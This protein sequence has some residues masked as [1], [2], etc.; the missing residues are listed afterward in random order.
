MS[1]LNLL[2]P[3]VDFVFKRI[4]GNE[5]HLNILTSF[6]NAVLLPQHP[7][8]SVTLKDTTIEKEHLEDKYSRLD[9]LAITNTGEQINIEIQLR[10]HH[11]FSKR[12]LYYWSKVYSSQL[13]QGA[14]Y[15]LLSKTICI[16]LLDFHYLPATNYHS[17][18]KVMNIE[19]HHLLSDVFE[20]HFIE[21]PKLKTFNDIKEIKNKLEAWIQFINAPE[22]EVVMELS[23]YETEINEAREELIRLSAN[24]TERA[25][26]ERRFES[27]IDKVDA[28]IHAE[29]RGEKRGEIRGEI[30]GKQ[31]KALEIATSLLDILDDDTIALKTGL[32]FD[33]VVQL[34]REHS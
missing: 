10:H 3:K 19:N 2:P 29:K 5:K 15:E 8:V 4:F 23:K 24:P 20:I 33:E 1:H 32:S 11:N 30:R 21:L 34:R 27:L 17:I 28:Q 26:Y 13:A 7:I 6:L 12:T 14:T 9:V 31:I 22:S 25:L 16:N 18:Y